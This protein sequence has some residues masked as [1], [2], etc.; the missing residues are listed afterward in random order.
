MLGTTSP[1]LFFNGGGHY[2]LA[3][4]D[5][6][7]IKSKIGAEVRAVPIR[8]GESRL[9]LVPLVQHTRWPKSRAQM[10]RSDPNSEGWEGNQG[11]RCNSPSSP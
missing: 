10:V 11:F 8:S 4:A 9:H 6:T 2:E 1:P 5:E 3:E 7:Q